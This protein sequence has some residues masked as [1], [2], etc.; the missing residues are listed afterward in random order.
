MK[1]AVSANSI[2]AQKIQL[3]NPAA[4]TPGVYTSTNTSV[5]SITA[6]LNHSATNTIRRAF[7]KGNPAFKSGIIPRTKPA[8]NP[9]PTANINV[10]M[11]LIAKA[12]PITIPATSPIPQ[13]TRQ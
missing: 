1:P 11:V 7:R 6:M 3:V 10:F 2:P 8:T 4:I 13:P 9:N 12:V 5:A